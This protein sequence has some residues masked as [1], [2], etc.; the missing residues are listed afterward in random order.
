[1]ATNFMNM[2]SKPEVYLMVPPPLYQDGAYN[3]NQTVINDVLPT[4]IPQMAADLGLPSKN[5]IDIY[6]AMGG[7]SLSSW[8]FFCDGQSCD[9][10]HPNDAGYAHVAS[11][12]YKRLFLTPL[13]TGTWQPQTLPEEDGNYSLLVWL[14][15]L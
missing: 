4:M 12:I 5:V 13:P 15:A 7:K 1:M 14:A 2:D 11:H 3:M 6:G 10:C 9:A 8:Q